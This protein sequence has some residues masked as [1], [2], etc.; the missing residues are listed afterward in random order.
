MISDV[1]L[2]T[3]TEGV[4]SMFPEDEQPDPLFKQHLIHGYQTCHEMAQGVPEDYLKMKGQIYEKMGRQKMF[5]ECA[6]VIPFIQY[7]KS[8]W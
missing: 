5:F 2:S 7:H 3:Y 6:N 8:K 4:W 1:L